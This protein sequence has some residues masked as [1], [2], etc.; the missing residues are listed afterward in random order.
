MWAGNFVVG[1]GIREALPPATM[2]FWRW[3]L[4]HWE[5]DKVPR[6]RGIAV[7]Q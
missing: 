5:L 1:R 7:D 3:A 6:Q 2:N 4:A